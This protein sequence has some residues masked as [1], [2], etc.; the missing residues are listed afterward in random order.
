[1]PKKGRTDAYWNDQLRQFA[2]GEVKFGVGQTPGKPKWKEALK[3]VM[4]CP[5]HGRVQTI[6]LLGRTIP[7]KCG[8]H[9]VCQMSLVFSLKLHV[10]IN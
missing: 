10:Y 2:N 8:Y 3:K 7:C 4:A 5:R 9:E 1:M 6:D